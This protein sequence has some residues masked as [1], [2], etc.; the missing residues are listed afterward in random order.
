[1]ARSASRNEAYLVIVGEIDALKD[2]LRLRTIALA[3]VGRP[4]TLT[5]RANRGLLE[6]RSLDSVAKY[7]LDTLNG[8]TRSA[9]TRGIAVEGVQLDYDCPTS[10]LPDYAALLRL[11]RPR[12]GKVALSV[13]ALPTWLDSRAFAVLAR[14]TEYYVLQVHSLDKP[15]TVDAP[16]VLFDHRKLPARLAR[17]SKLRVPYFVALPTYGYQV[18]FDRSGRFLGLGAENAPA[19]ANAKTVMADPVEL[20]QVVAELRAQTPAY[21]RGI[22]WFRLPVEGDT[23]NWS[24]PTLESVM[25]GKAPSTLPSVEVRRPGNNLF[26]VWIT[27]SAGYGTG[28]DLVVRLRWGNAT[29]QASDALGGFVE[30]SRNA[31]STAL[32]GP[33]PGGEPAMAA[34]YRVVDESQGTPQLEKVEWAQ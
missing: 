1:V 19:L 34:W 6:D 12:L 32:R 22:V 27:N 7:L 10:R 2:P 25:D 23:L 11:L 9:Q 3:K 29:V 24:W 17:A 18:A 15:T 4:V 31:G 26:E 16:V 30:T 8:I 13:T 28:K 33:C 20:A 14:E 21:C 5:L